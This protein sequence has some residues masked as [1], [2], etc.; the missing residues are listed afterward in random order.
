MKKSL[1]PKKKALLQALIGEGIFLAVSA[2]IMALVCKTFLAETVMFGT[3]PLF[4]YAVFVILRE[5]FR[6]RSEAGTTFILFSHLF[7]LAQALLFLVLFLANSLHGLLYYFIIILPLVGIEVIFLIIR[8]VIFLV[9]GEESEY[10][11]LPDEEGDTAETPKAKGG[12]SPIAWGLIVVTVLF[13]LINL[14]DDDLFNHTTRYLSYTKADLKLTPY[15]LTEKNPKDY[16]AIRL[17]Y[18]TK[19]KIEYYYIEGADRTTVVYAFETTKNLLSQTTYRHFLYNGKKVADLGSYMTP[20]SITLSTDTKEVTVTDAATLSALW[21]GYL[22]A[23]REHGVGEKVCDI[24]LHFFDDPR[25]TMPGFIT[26][27]GTDFFVMV[28]SGYGLTA[29]FLCDKALAESLL[30]SLEE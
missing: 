27:N 28:K 12:L 16:D 23:D 14:T 3:L 2:G 19:N 21:Q 18:D 1:S 5:T 8:F 26:T 30:A 29:G 15:F 6:K 20:T 11:T 22:T 4:S 10:I 13:G 9:K 24:T 25:L 17:P 7:F